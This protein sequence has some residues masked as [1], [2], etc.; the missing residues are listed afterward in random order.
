MRARELL[1]L[2]GLPDKADE[3]PGVLSGGQ[4]QRL[5]IARALANEP[6]L[7]LADE[8][9]GALDSVGGLE[10]LELFRRLHAGGQTIL[11]VTH[12]ARVADAAERVVRMQDGRIAR[13]DDRTTGRPRRRRLSVAAVWMRFRAELRSRWRTWLTLAV[14]AGIAG[15]FVI[16]GIAGARRT[17]SALAR[18]LHAYRFP[19]ATVFADN[20]AAEA[21]GIV[22]SRRSSPNSGSA[23]CA[24]VGSRL[25]ARVLRPRREEQARNRHW[26]AGGAVSW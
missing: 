20:F 23:A 24:G 2:L 25:G 14:L 21:T 22:S 9:T 19:D 17:D 26:P 15:G 7:L 1:D 13:G 16:A 6:T 12:D 10:V 5:A 18:H 11:L 8:P 4:R 3:L